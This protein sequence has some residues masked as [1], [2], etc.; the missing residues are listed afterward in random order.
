MSQP[1]PRPGRRGRPPERSGGPTISVILPCRDAA[2]WLPACIGSLER[3]T[4]RDFEVLAVDDGSTDET[5]SLLEAWLARDER[6]RVLRTGGTGLVAALRRA[7]EEARGTLWAR[8][9][10]D[11]VAHPDRLQA[12]RCFLM[13][14]PDLAG[15]GTGVRYFPRH[16]LGS[17]YRRYESWLNS[18]HDPR[19]LA[20]DLFVEC[21][22]AHPTLMLRAEAYRKVGGYRDV[23][24]PEDYDL[25]LR[26]H[27][28][29]LRMANLPRVLLQ[30]RVWPGRLSAQSPV[31]SPESFLRCKVHHLMRGYLAAGRPV[32]VWGAG[33]VGKRL[34]RELRSQG[35]QPA[36]FVELDPRKIGQQMHGAR[37]LSPEELG[38][39]WKAGGFPCGSRDCLAAGQAAERPY[40]LVAVG[41]PG[42][43]QEIRQ[44][45]CRLGMREGTDFRAAA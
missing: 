30:W 11:D 21:P 33:R 25:I 24:W 41:T 3:Q 8:M 20:R 17:G 42:A 45:L 23:G 18:L 2:R 27:R 19:E 22:I 10:A 7:V 38:R 34:A 37:V 43:R 6:V 12:Q 44:A 28:E 14:R 15:C 5:R 13:D 31:Y 35:C 36:A 26:L 39:L 16:S 32:I 9:D 1:G 4:A 29:G 40:V